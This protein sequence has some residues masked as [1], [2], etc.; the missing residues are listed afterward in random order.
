MKKKKTPEKVTSWCRGSD[1][2]VQRVS[3]AEL[4]G[5]VKRDIEREEE[6]N[7]EMDDENVRR[8]CDSTS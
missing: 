3:S 6:G 4:R 1:F 5:V 8:G 2:D 7:E